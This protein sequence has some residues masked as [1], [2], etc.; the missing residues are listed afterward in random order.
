MCGVIQ[1]KEDDRLS[2]KIKVSYQ[3]TS[4]L[5]RVLKC[6]LP[7]GIAYK[8]AKRQDGQFKKAYIEGTLGK[9]K[10]FSACAEGSDMLF[11]VI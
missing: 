3:N 8:V 4:E 6:L 9:T 10:I 11:L 1:K 5:Q 2:V 7:L